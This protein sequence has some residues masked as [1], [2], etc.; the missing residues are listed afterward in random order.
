MGPRFHEL[1]WGPELRALSLEFGAKAEALVF[2]RKTY[3]G[4]AAYWPD[5]ED[6]GEI[7]A[8]MN[9]LPKLVAS[10]TLT[11]PA[12]NNSRA[13]ADIVGELRALKARTE[14]AIYIFGSGELMRSLLPEGVIDEIMLALVPVLLGQGTRLFGEG[15]QVPLRLVSSQPDRERD[16]APELR[17]RGE[18]ECAPR[19]V[20]QSC[21]PGARTL[22]LRQAFAATCCRCGRSDRRR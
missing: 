17:G 18:P 6:E 21:N 2:G 4:M 11:E 3:E 9:A 5:A 12:W 7:K 15:P 19:G 1:A 8:Y 22:P 13:T 20:W 16:G 10:R 14:K